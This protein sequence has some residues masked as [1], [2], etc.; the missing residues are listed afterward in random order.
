[1]KFNILLFTFI[2]TNFIFVGPIHATDQNMEKSIQKVE[3]RN[4]RQFVFEYNKNRTQKMLELKYVES[5]RANLV[6]G[7]AIVAKLEFARNSEITLNGYLLH[8]ENFKTDEARKSYFYRVLDYQKVNK[9]PTTSLFRIFMPEAFAA[10]N[11]D[12]VNQNKKL[13]ESLNQ[14]T[15]EWNKKTDWVV[16]KAD[17]AMGLDRS[18]VSALSV[19]L[20]DS[21]TVSAD[22]NCDDDNSYLTSNG[23]DHGVKMRDGDKGRTII[24]DR[25]NDKRIEIRVQPSA[26]YGNVKY[27]ADVKQFKFSSCG[28]YDSSVWQ[29]KCSNDPGQDLYATTQ[30]NLPSDVSTETLDKAKDPNQKLALA[31]IACCENVKSSNDKSC[32][33]KAKDVIDSKKYYKGSVGAPLGTVEQRK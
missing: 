12:E 25:L 20:K 9:K 5:T 21:N 23:L 29:E 24:I 2:I 8:T 22:I 1:M 17:S 15:K 10:V 32:L 13:V 18:E 26:I 11:E 4:F 16:Y 3:V 31:L 14:L 27:M 19:L 30:P 7:E 33:Q 6:S 28:K